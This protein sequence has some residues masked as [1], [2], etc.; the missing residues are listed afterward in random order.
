MW[1]TREEQPL[2]TA[3]VF[4]T[5]SSVMNGLLATACAHYVGPIGRWRLLFIIVGAIT[6]A[7]ALLLFW[8]LPANPT[9]AWWLTLRQRAIITQRMA[10]ARTGMHNSTFKWSQ[11][12]EAVKDPKT[13]LIFLINVVLNIP[14]GGLIT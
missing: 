8:L 14:N 7:W 4:S 9:T 13:W 2:R 6:T 5:L 10:K 3:I 11:A 1:Y 12:S